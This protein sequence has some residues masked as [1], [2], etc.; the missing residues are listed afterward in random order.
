M[1]RSRQPPNRLAEGSSHIVVAGRQ[2]AAY[3][4]APIGLGL[5]PSV[6]LAQRLLTGVHLFPSRVRSQPLVLYST[7][8]TN[9][10]IHGPCSCPTFFQHKYE[11]RS[12]RHFNWR[13]SW[14][15]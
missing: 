9:P 2:S 14:Y 7:R 13:R 5:G 15:E 12:K 3:V 6:A 4:A 8:S 11:T 1:R 10:C